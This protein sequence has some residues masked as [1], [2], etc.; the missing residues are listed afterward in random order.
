METT[1]KQSHL[2]T[3]LDEEHLEILRNK[4]P[5][6]WAEKVKE[7]TGLSLSKIRMVLRNPELYDKIVIDATIE[8]AN[9][10][11]VDVDSTIQNQKQKIYD[12]IKE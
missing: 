8:V 4:L 10:Y 3:K 9:E 6:D 11:Q 2:S 1:R 12:L 7:K 5:S